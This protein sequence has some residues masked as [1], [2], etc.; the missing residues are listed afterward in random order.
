LIDWLDSLVT[1]HCEHWAAEHWM[2]ICILVS[3]WQAEIVGPDDFDVGCA[4]CLIPW[5]HG[6]WLLLFNDDLVEFESII[7]RLVLT[8]EL[9]VHW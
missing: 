4:V 3:D 2:G 6:P 9:V 1:E 5:M 8:N 7:M